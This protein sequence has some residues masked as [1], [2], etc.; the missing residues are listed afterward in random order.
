MVLKLLNMAMFIADKDKRNIVL[1]D[2]INYNTLNVRNI[3]K[4]EE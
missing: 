4:C 3:T 1:I 2:L